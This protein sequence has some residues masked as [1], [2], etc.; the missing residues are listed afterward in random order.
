MFKNISDQFGSILV[1]LLS[2]QGVCSALA[3]ETNQTL[4]EGSESEHGELAVR[5]SDEYTVVHKWDG[6]G[7]AASSGVGL[8]IVG[9]ANAFI[10]YYGNKPD[11]QKICGKS[12]TIAT[13]EDGV[14]Y[15]YYVYSYTTGSNCDSTQR[16]K[17][18]TNKL[19]DAFDELHSEGASAV[20]LDLDHHGTWHGVVGL[21][22]DASG[23]DPKSACSDHHAGAK[24]S[25]AGFPELEERSPAKRD[26]IGLVKRTPISVSESDKK[27][28]STKFSHPN[29]SQAVILGIADKIYQQS[30]A[31]SCDGITGSITDTNGVSYSYYYYASGRNCDTTAQLKTIVSAL[32]DAWEGLGSTSALCMTMDHGGTW[33]GHL[34]ISAM[35]GTYPSQKLC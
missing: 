1:A 35:Q 23:I 5:T 34:G 16:A 8:V 32:D 17:T 15:K 9:I 20:C 10:S 3:V 19:S 13:T 21:A 4:V 11:A 6:G 29:K 26:E 2:I 25:N 18:I 28:G 27:S 12:A 33:R 7:I 30:A 14:G 24:R 22:T 31:G